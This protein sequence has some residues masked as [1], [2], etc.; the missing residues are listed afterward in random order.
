MNYGYALLSQDGVYLD[1]YNQNSSVL[2]YQLYDHA[3]MMNGTFKD[4]KG[5]TLLEI[6]CGRGGCFKFMLQEFKPEVAIGIDY[7]E[8]NVK[9]CQATIGTSN[10]VKFLQGDSQKLFEHEALVKGMADVI[11]NIESSHCYP[12]LDGFYS[13]V[14]YLLKDEG[15]FI[16]ADFCMSTE[17]EAIEDLLTQYFDI[18]KKD[19]IRRNVLHSLDLQQEIKQQP[20]ELYCPWYLKWFMKNFLALKDSTMYNEFKSKQRTY[21]AYALRK[22]KYE[23]D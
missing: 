11:V 5:K 7:S 20:F 9:F 8:E 15:I 18:I 2:Q 13:S 19:D 1:E 14:Y 6:G 4:M 10:K 21:F 17:I 22:K 23:A 12:N 3:I 16:Y